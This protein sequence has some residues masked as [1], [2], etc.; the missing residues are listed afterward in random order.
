MAND[1]VWYELMTTDAKAARDFYTKVVGWKPQDAAQPG[2][3]YTLL[4]SGDAP[5]AGLMTLPKEA[6][7][8]GTKP[9]WIGYVGVSDV[10]A[11]A[12]RVAKAGG[13][14]H[15]PPTDIPNI[16]RFAM[17]ADPQG[18]VFSL[19]KPLSDMPPP[20]ADPATPGTI[21]WHEL[22]AARRPSPSMPSCSA[23]PRTRRSTW[24]RWAD[25]SSSPPAVLRS[26]A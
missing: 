13:A 2:M 8:A 21:G 16:G 7:D 14:V 18:A 6:C 17:V 15:V 24:A 26:A 3:D 1:F 9:G 23:G 19:F 11:Y 12:G 20:P 10:D 25:T 5:M 22:M 4:L